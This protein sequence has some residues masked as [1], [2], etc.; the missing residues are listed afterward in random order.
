MKEERK[1][2]LGLVEQG[3]LSVD[4]ALFLIEE[5]EKKEQS[6]EEKKAAIM[7]ELSTS[8]KSDELSF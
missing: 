4:E 6:M 3:K 7:T 5:L 8:V 2:I 1:R